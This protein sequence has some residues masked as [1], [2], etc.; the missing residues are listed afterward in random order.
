MGI[1][2]IYKR[3][4]M[5]GVGGRRDIFKGTLNKAIK[6]SKQLCLFLSCTSM[7]VELGV[8]PRIIFRNKAY[9]YQKWGP[10]AVVEGD[11][12]KGPQSDF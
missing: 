7:C 4:Q 3:Q 9:D 6:E 8:W 10:R 1:R 11:V 5:V 12:D 2:F